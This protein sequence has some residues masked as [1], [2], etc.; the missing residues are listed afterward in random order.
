MLERT[1]RLEVIPVV[2]HCSSMF[3]RIMPNELNL[4]FAAISQNF[5]QIY[6]YSNSCLEESNSV[7][8]VPYL[9]ELDGSPWIEANLFLFDI[10]KSSTLNQSPNDKLR[11][12][13][14]T[15]LDY[16]IFCEGLS[17]ELYDFS[18]LRPVNRPTYRYFKSLLD[19]DDLSG[20]VLNQKTKV[21]Y[22]FYNYV[23]KKGR[24][25]FDIERVDITRSITLLISTKNGFMAK[26]AVKR[27]QTVP[28]LPAKLVPIGYVRDEGENL[29]PLVGDEFNSLITALAGPALQLEQRLIVL[30]ALLTGERKQTILTLRIHHL[31]QFNE[32]NL[33][34]DGLYRFKVSPSNGADTKLNRPH[35]L[36]VPKFLAEM[37]IRYSQCAAYLSRVAK[38][39]RVHGSILKNGDMY[40]FIS[41]E[42]N[43]YYMAK[44]DPRYFKVRTR[45]SGGNT[46]TI[47]NSLITAACGGLPDNFSFHWLRATFAH[48][49][50]ET[51]RPLVALGKLKHGDDIS[52]IQKRL[53]HCHRETTENY[54][55]LFSTVNERLVAQEKYESSLFGSSLSEIT[56]RLAGGCIE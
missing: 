43:C 6:E 26:E 2:E 53:H 46:K 48:Q 9:F 1:Q 50:Y 23:F 3:S 37:L 17:V 28:Q 54:L 15:L 14:W 45:P 49:L 13:A 16:K 44:N 11:R 38:F 19:R 7:Y 27:S 18:A 21:I 39:E 47:T 12:I 51:L 55:K 29:R 30:L 34:N 22:D 24:Y 35:L 32:S 40:L 5:Y 8:Q 4:G 42:G 25:Q 10:A 36:Y 41:R 56:S 20:R 52:L 31:G 33:G